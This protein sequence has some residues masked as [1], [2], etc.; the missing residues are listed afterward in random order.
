ME[1]LKPKALSRPQ[2][3]RHKTLEVRFWE[4]VEKTDGCWTWKAN[5]RGGYGQF[6]VNGRMQPAHRV[7]L[8]LVGR[9]VPEGKEIDHLC[10]NRACVNPA[11]LD[12]VTRAENIRRRPYS[13]EKLNKTVCAV[14]H[15]LV[16]ENRWIAHWRGRPELMCRI[17]R[18]KAQAASILAR[19][20]RLEEE[21]KNASGVGA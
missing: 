2:D 5:T 3:V 17:C 10:M 11:H 13:A 20:A 21:Q 19:V 16:G 7:S 9:T 12:V 8:W 18:L 1:E 15:A 4:K 14:G 6:A